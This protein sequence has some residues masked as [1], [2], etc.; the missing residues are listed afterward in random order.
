MKRFKT[1]LIFSSIFIIAGMLVVWGYSRTSGVSYANPEGI[2]QGAS[3]AGGEPPGGSGDEGPYSPGK[4]N[5]R[6]DS[7]KPELADKYELELWIHTGIC[8]KILHIKK[9][10]KGNPVSATLTTEHGI[11]DVTEFSF[12][13]DILKFHAIIGSDGKEPL[14]F[15]LKVYRQALIGE[16]DGPNGIEPV[17]AKDPAQ[18]EGET[19]DKLCAPSKL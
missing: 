10:A 19:S 14:D 5:W 12:D 15:K 4:I 7:G 17:V 16:L 2:A 18:F 6:N 9:D 1:V 11:Q 13:G 3:P 8:V